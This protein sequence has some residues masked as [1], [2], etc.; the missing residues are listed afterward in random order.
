MFTYRGIPTTRCRLRF[1]T[2]VLSKLTYGLPAYAYS[3]PELTTVQNF[4]RRY[5]IDIYSVLEQVNRSLFEKTSSIPDYPLYPYIP[6]TK[7]I[8]ARPLKARCSAFFIRWIRCPRCL[9]CGIRV[10][11]DF[12][13]LCNAVEMERERLQTALVLCPLQSIIND[14]ISEARNMGFLA[15]SFVD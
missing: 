7:E 10:E 14:Q 15:S 2:I 8:P 4:L 9:S 1:R 5:Q 13:S 11:F 3:I 6:K 12:P